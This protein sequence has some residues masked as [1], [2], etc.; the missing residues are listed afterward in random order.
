MRVKV[1]QEVKK[2]LVVTM[3]EYILVVVSIIGAYV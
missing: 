3:A 2:V 1:I